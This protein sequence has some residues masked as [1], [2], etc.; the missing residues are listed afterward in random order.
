MRKNKYISFYQFKTYF[1]RVLRLLVLIICFVCTPS[2]LSAQE[3]R[4]G[5]DFGGIAFKVAPPVGV[6]GE[7]FNIGWGISAM[8]EYVL[9]KSWSISFDITYLRWGAKPNDLIE[10]FTMIAFTAAPKVYVWN[11][12][13]CSVEIGGFYGTIEAKRG[14]R[15]MEQY[16]FG[17]VPVIGYH[18]GVWDFAVEYAFVRNRN[19]V[20]LRAGFYLFDFQL[21]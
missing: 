14:Q 9:F 5:E 4:S 15:F 1:M 7:A 11:N 20:N 19:W 2:I 21:N 10:S 12:V 13:Y 17:V 8:N 3:R 16:Q 6:F 18:K